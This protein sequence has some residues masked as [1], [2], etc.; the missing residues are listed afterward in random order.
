MI[1]GGTGITPM[2]QVLAAIFSNPNDKTCVKMIFANQTE[3]D[4]LVRSELETIAKENP[5]RFQLHYTLDRPPTT[6][7]NYS[8]GFVTKEMMEEHLYTPNG[9]ATQTFLCGP[10][11]MIKYACLPNLEAMGF[12]SKDWFSF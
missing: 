6:G 7:W 9:K 4:I 2:L 8:T 11:P 10:P 12:T 5:D 3:E 1:A